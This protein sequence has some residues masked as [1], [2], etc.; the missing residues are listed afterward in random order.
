MVDPDTRRVLGPGEPGE[1]VVRGPQLLTGYWKQEKAF[2][3][4]WTEIDGRRARS[5]FRK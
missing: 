2:A 4:S 1:I 3:E 5:R